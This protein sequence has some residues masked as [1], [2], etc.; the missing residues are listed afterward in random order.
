VRADSLS[1]SRPV[2]TWLQNRHPEHGQ[3]ERAGRLGTSAA[4][5][6]SLRMCGSALGPGY[7][8]EPGHNDD[9]AANL[10][11]DEP[12]WSGS[13]RD[14]TEGA[15]QRSR[16]RSGRYGRRTRY[17]VKCGIE[18]RLQSQAA[19]RT[20]PAQDT[21]CWTPSTTSGARRSPCGSIG[22][23]AGPVVV[24]RTVGPAVIKQHC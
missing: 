7:A 9:Q 21:G 16:S 10:A 18:R 4:R 22:P 1:R 5:N 2:K 3:A 24:R 8:A 13:T 12:S 15:A 11:C 19:V 6:K 14:A 23:M 20:Q 17:C